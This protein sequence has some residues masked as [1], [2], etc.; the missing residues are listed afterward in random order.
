MFHVLTGSEAHP[1]PGIKRPGHQ[2]DDSLPTTAE[3]KT[4]VHISTPPHVFSAQCLVKHRNRF[5]F[6]NFISELFSR[7]PVVVVVVFVPRRVIKFVTSISRGSE[8]EY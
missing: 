3:V 6:L 7:V 1:A 4:W 5:L 8:Y 2:A